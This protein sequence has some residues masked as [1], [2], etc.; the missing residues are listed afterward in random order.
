MLIA[1]FFSPVIPNSNAPDKLSSQGPK[2]NVDFFFFIQIYSS[3]TYYQYVIW[4]KYLTYLNLGLLCYKMKILISIIA[5]LLLLSE[6]TLLLC[7]APSFN[8]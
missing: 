4:A 1:P 7:N 3:S 5:L 8:Q 2:H 6:L